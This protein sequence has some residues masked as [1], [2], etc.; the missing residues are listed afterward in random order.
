MTVADDRAAIATLVADEIWEEAVALTAAGAVLQRTWSTGG[1]H[2]VGEVRGTLA[3]PYVTSVTLGR[4]E[5]GAVVSFRSTCACPVVRN[6]AHGVALA[7]SG[8]DEPAPI[9]RLLPGPT[10]GRRLDDDG[11]WELPLHALLDGEADEA[12][13]VVA[14][15]ES[16]I[17]LQ[18]E[19]L[20]DVGRTPVDGPGVRIR[21]VQRSK[22]GAWVRTGISWS[23][24]DYYRFGAK[25][26]ARAA[27]R[28]E[29]LKELRELS[30]LSSGAA[31][32]YTVNEVVRLETIHSRR[33]WDLLTEAQSLGLPLVHSGG[34]GAPVHLQGEPAGVT[35]D[36]V[37][38]DDGLHVEPRIATEELAV[39][40]PRS[41]LIGRPAHG[42]AWWSDDPRP[43]LGMAPLNVLVDDGLR[44][45]L[46]TAAVDVP[47]RDEKRF[48][49]VFVPRI[50]RRVD[51]SSSDGSVDLPKVRQSGIVLSVGADEVGTVLVTWERGAPD[52]GWR[53]ELWASG[54]RSVDQA[55]EDAIL[56]RVVEIVSEL[57]ELFQRSIRGERLA[58]ES[59][60]R[61]MA[62]VRFLT[63]LVPVLESVP[64][65]RIERIGEIPEFRESIEAP[66]VELGG[67]SSE[68]RDWFDLTVQVT[69]GGERVPFAELFI[70]LAEGQSHLVLPS[71]TYFSLDHES[72]RELDAL[73]AEARAL[74]DV[75]GD[76]LRIS[77][78]QASLWEDLQHIGIVTAQID[79]WQEAVRSLASATD[80]QDRPIPRGLQATLRPYQATG[81]HW[82]ASLFE[83]GLGGV[84]A[85]DMGLGK[86]VQALALMLHA[87]EQGLSR[88]PF[89]VVAPT[90]VVGNWATECRRFAPD[91]RVA[92]VTETG[93]RRGT[94][95]AEVAHQAD[96][97]VTSYS[98][99]RIEYDSYA[100][101]SW[102]AL[103]LD[104][105]QFAK[106]R[107][108][109]TYQRAKLLPVGVKVA[110]SGTPIEN[111]LMELWS[112]LSITAPG[113]F[114]SADRFGEYYRI[115]VEKHGDAERLEHLRK[116]VRPL[117]LRRT[118]E[119]VASELPDKQE[120]V[121]ELELHPRHKKVYETYLHRERQK[122][123]GL[124]D[125]LGKHRFAI[126]RSLTLLRQASLDVSLVDP[127]H[128]DVPSTKL[129][130]LMEML[131]DI[132]ADGHRVL[133]FSQFTRFLGRARDRIAAAGI[134]HCYLDGSTR[135]RAQVID[136]F[137]TGEAPVFLISLKAGGFGLNLTEADYCIILDPWWNPATEAQA[138]DRI[139]RI[140]QTKKVMVY[141]LI[142]KG[143]LEEKVMALK[144]AKAQLFSS[145]IDGG[146]FE[147]AHLT[148]SDIQ[149][150]LE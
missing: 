131:E 6:C 68:D 87:R 101:V 15:E 103:F 130:A 66:I 17:A 112:L 24:L 80:E 31:S 79:A 45:F 38:T 105:A 58:P 67:T 64:G 148:A 134:D 82:L 139:H 60:L 150:L 63:E 21:P 53:E 111:S 140:G 138:V 39:P 4:D 102:A 85:D 106:N 118:K 141:R 100:E 35:I 127:A 95:I 124:L 12:R 84:L 44:T 77:R 72:L 136:E 90:S 121:L 57:P 13:A 41:M 147:S 43:E 126:F 108:S 37:R 129:D 73:I 25:L 109:Q 32:R 59:Q 65:L 123:L 49:R 10:A 146:G 40:L 27:G 14:L 62:A 28:L 97:V 142:A 122:V 135:N 78:Y 30:R 120:Q 114:P 81:F 69:V 98:L 36:V 96:L 16:E 22:S 29:L 71:G 46:R 42:I 88:A 48:L 144:A 107:L 47:L 76:T 18:F 91:L 94:T 137:R 132:V 70:A 5:D 92:T 50:R 9:L 2:V 119:Q 19:L 115:P 128:A 8:E 7:I 125:D 86:T 89:L 93:R 75:P 99:F 33:L 145:V 34:R 83:H 116:R 54:S 143:T 61:G 3:R 23:S 56:R 51:V 1:T 110:M 117:L 149:E 55:A 113:L 52:G 11:A 74:Q 133:I 20:L 26:S 104:E